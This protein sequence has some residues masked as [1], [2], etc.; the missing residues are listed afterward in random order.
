[1]LGNGQDRVEYESRGSLGPDESPPKD[2]AFVWYELDDLALE[3]A[4]VGSRLDMPD[5]KV[6]AHARLN[7]GESD[8]DPTG[9][10][11]NVRPA[12]EEILSVPG[13]LTVTKRTS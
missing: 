12:C 11:P 13:A 8:R 7:L 3:P 6:A 10:Q 2:D 4:D 1:M 9:S 5:A